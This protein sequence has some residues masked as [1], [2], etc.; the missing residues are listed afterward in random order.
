LPTVIRYGGF[1]VRILFPPREHGPPHVHVVKGGGEVVIR[2]AEI[3]GH[4]E[5]VQV[6]GM[7]TADTVK[8]ISLIERWNDELLAMWKAIHGD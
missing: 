1:V 4:V 3:G 7:R 6:T 2:L 8:A 5:I